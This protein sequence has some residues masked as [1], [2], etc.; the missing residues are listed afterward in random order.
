MRLKNTAVVFASAAGRERFRVRSVEISRDLAKQSAVTLRFRR[1]A[2]AVSIKLSFPDSIRL[3]L[4][5]YRYTT[6]PGLVTD[7][8]RQHPGVPLPR[9]LTLLLPLEHAAVAFTSAERHE[10]IPVYEAEFTRSLTRHT[11]RLAFLSR[12]KALLTIHLPFAQSVRLLFD[13]YHQV[14]DRALWEKPRGKR[15]A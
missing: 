10:E 12:G 7:W 11:D 15:V 2:G 4:S 5:S 6:K 14:I 8:E 13:A 9:S 1:S 3:L